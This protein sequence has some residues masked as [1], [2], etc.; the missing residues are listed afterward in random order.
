M[1]KGGLILMMCLLSWAMEAKITWGARAGLSYSSLTQIVDDQVTYGGRLGFS[2]AGL[3][4]IPLS[5]K[6]SICPELAFVNQGG[7]YGYIFLVNDNR[8]QGQH[9]CNY[10]SLQLPVNLV[11]KINLG[12]WQMG[13]QAG[14][15][16]S[17]STRERERHEWKTRDFRPFDIGAGTG[18]YVEHRRVFFSVYAQ[19][20]FI[21][22]LREKQPSESQIYQNDVTFSFGYQFR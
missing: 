9:T 15:F 20:G 22:K 6:F 17:V 2:V 1:K 16:F 10:Y 19:T 8:K 5:R 3:A 12:S 13:I 4:D 18:L 21:N 7:S 11:Y 14:P